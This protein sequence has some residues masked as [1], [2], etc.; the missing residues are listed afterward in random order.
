MATDLHLPREVASAIGDRIRHAEL[1]S[2]ADFPQTSKDED[3]IVES[4]GSR[5][6]C[7]QRTVEVSTS[8]VYERR[9]EW[10][11]SISHTRFRGRGRGALE[12]RVGADVIIELNVH[13]AY[14]HRR[15]SLLIQAKKNWIT[16]ARVFEQAARLITWRE[17][18]SVV[19]LTSKRFEGF[20]IDDVIKGRGKRPGSFVQLS[21]F[22]ISQFVAG[23][24]GDDS[25]EYD[26]RHEWL[27]WLD[28][29]D[30]LV[31]CIFPCKQRISIN[32]STPPPWKTPA[33]IKPEEIP[34]HR[35]AATPKQLL[36]VEKISDVDE[37]KRAYRRRQNIYHPDKHLHVPRHV[38]EQLKRESQVINI[39]YAEINEN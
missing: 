2:I 23:E 17:A 34:E 36:G 18:A 15:K 9:G 1:A 27:Q 39:A 10:K 13:D 16:D 24:L 19:N 28:M 26:P 5:V 25:I 8:N 14:R 29:N 4:F 31:R 12:K 38:Q 22:L 30:V 3:S 33:T 11:W 20:N 37:L 32:V 7:R 35:L 6:R 21:D